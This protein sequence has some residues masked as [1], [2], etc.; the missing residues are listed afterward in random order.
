MK[1]REEWRPVLD[2]EVERW[3]EKSYEELVTELRELQNYEVVCE[4][5]RYQVEV[6]I[7]ENTNAY[8][9]VA[10]GV[11]DGSVPASFFPLCK[12]FKRQKG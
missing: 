1:R 3:S 11:D 9:L 7:L 6:E 10:I 8:L 5:K 2:A 12:T 4:S